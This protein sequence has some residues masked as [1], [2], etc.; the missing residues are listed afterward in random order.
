MEIERKDK[1]FAGEASPEG[2]SARPRVRLPERGIRLQGWLSYLGAGLIL[3]VAGYSVEATGWQ[4]APIHAAGLCI[5]VVVAVVLAVLP[6]YLD[7]ALR[8]REVRPR[9]PET[10]R[11]LREMVAHLNETRS[12]I[13]YVQERADAVE[14]FARETGAGEELD[15]VVV[16]LELRL[17]VLEAQVAALTE[18]PTRPEGGEHG[19]DASEIAESDRP[20]EIPEGGFLAKALGSNKSGGSGGAVRRIVEEGRA[21][22]GED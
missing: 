8:I 11:C 5:A 14:S 6:G 10:D 15:E 7:F 13:L 21:S 9:H 18:R 20:L 17:E 2:H 4:L 1:R 3:L 16:G 22:E 12:A 19:G